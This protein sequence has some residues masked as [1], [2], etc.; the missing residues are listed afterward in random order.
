MMLLTTKCMKLEIKHPI[1]Y[2]LNFPHQPYPTQPERKTNVSRTRLFD[3][4]NSYLPPSSL[5][6]AYK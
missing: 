2:H 6:V 5:K 1:D 4:P 3:C